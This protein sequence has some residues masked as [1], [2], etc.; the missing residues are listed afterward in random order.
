MGKD[1]TSDLINR[2]DV[3][4]ELKEQL[5]SE[6]DLGPTELDARITAGIAWC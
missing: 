5:L 1:R 6:L 3:D 2:L 4:S